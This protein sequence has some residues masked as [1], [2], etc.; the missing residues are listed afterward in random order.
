MFTIYMKTNV[1]LNVV[2]GDTEEPEAVLIRAGEPLEGGE[3]IKFNRSGRIKNMSK[4][5]EMD[6]T[7]GPGKLGQAFGVD[8]E[9][10]GCDFIKNDQFY[11][12][13]ETG[14]CLGEDDIVTSSRINID[15]SGPQWSKKPWRFHIRGN[16]YVSKK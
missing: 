5:K 11:V 2:T 15:S 4:K 1:C 13:E 14:Y 7:N 10:S 16:P 3:E 9:W 12:E 8:T 6:L